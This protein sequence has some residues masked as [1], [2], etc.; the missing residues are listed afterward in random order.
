MSTLS[1]SCFILLSPSPLG[2]T[3]NYFS[4]SHASLLFHLP[5]FHSCITREEL[6]KNKILKTLKTLKFLKTLKTL[7]NRCNIITPQRVKNSQIHQISSLYSN[8]PDSNT[9]CRI[10]NQQKTNITLKIIAGDKF[11]IWQ[12][13]KNLQ[14]HSAV[15]LVKGITIT[16]TSGRTSG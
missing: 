14:T 9:N 4:K 7:N 8:F 2:P 1:Q 11:P 5:T 16:M 3:L 15:E 6:F 12:P 13:S 10:T